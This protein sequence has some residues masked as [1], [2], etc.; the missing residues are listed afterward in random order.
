MGFITTVSRSGREV[1]ACEI[2][3][4]GC[5]R[6]GCT[7]HRCPYGWCQR[8]YV[9]KACWAKPD[10]KALFTKRG[11]KHETCRVN[12]DAYRKRDIEA[13]ALRESGHLL[14]VAALNKDKKG[15]HVI[16]RGKDGVEAGRYMPKSV[17]DGIPIGTN[18]T[19]EDYE[20]IAGCVLSTAP[21]SF[22]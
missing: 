4:D 11:G 5:A 22:Y 16:F 3:K 12:S 6:T 20:K 13:D 21:T 14:R 7:K 19:I 17:Y 10:V 9:C 18:A 1:F 15:V 8:Y 2:G